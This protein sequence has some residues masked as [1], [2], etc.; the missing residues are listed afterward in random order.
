MLEARV[1]QGGRCCLQQVQSQAPSQEAVWA[2]MVGLWFP[3]KVPR[4][5]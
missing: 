1:F 5:Q 4:G 3:P 2:L